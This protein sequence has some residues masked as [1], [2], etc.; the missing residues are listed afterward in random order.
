MNRREHMR[1]RGESATKP[2]SP[3]K[4]LWAIALPLAL[5]AVFMVFVVV[6]LVFAGAVTVVAGFGVIGS[7]SATGLLGLGCGLA[8]IGGATLLG[9]GVYVIFVKCMPVIVRGINDGLNHIQKRG[10]K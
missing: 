5:V 6:G 10:I 2:Q 4:E 7:S 1:E 9:V 3:K 8:L